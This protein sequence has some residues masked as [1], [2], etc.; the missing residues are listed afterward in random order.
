MKKK[1]TRKAAKR[2]PFKVHVFD[3]NWWS[4]ENGYYGITKDGRRY[5]AMILSRKG[6]GVGQ[7]AKFVGSFTTLTAAK[8]KLKSLYDRGITYTTAKGEKF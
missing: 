7:K 1:Q 6:R 2:P 4:T 3:H 8:K 5:D